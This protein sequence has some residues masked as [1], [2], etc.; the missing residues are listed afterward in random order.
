MTLLTSRRGQLRRWAPR[1]LPSA[2]RSHRGSS[3]RPRSS[4]SPAATDSSSSR[5]ARSEF[6]SSVTRRL[7]RGAL[8][9]R[10]GVHIESHRILREMCDRRQA[11]GLRPPVA[12]DD[13]ALSHTDCGPTSGERTRTA[14]LSRRPSL[15]VAAQPLHQELR[16]TCLP[17][18][19]PSVASARRREGLGAMLC[20]R[21][22][23]WTTDCG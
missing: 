11:P 6:C 8:G 18:E 14:A 1:R 12:P 20:R 23:G 17:N 5:T 19:H 2:A 16:D 9:R 21:T 4:G 7:R 3:T 15:T 13:A 10:P 22:D